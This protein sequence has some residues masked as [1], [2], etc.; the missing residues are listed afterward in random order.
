LNFDPSH[1]YWLGIDPIQALKDYSEKIFHAHAKDTE[2]IPEGEY[3]YGIAGKQIDPEP[4][5]SGWWR[6]RIPGLGEIDW[7]IFISTLQEYGYDQFLS[8]EHEDPVW[9]GSEEK[10][11][12]GL[13]LGYK[14]L[15]QFVL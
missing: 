10:I 14:H 5:K 1:L 6:Y 12:A 15:S 11:K 4:W 8:I 7:N 13:K 9:E 2:I 3:R